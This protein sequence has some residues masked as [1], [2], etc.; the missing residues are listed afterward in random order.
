MHYKGIVLSDYISWQ[1]LDDIFLIVD[2]RKNQKYI[3]EGTSQ[4]IM[5]M[6][7]A[8]KSVNYIVN[9]LV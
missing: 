4:E 6:I 7:V 3:L 1:N 8:K 2:E 5:L 9:A